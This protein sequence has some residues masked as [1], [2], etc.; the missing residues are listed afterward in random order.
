MAVLRYASGALVWLA[1]LAVLYLA[2]MYN[3]NL[4]HSAA[5]LFSV[6]VALTIFVIAWNTRTILNNNYLLFLG[7]A[8]LFIGVVDV[9]HTLAYKGMGVF[10]GYDANLPTQLWL[11][12]RYL[13]AG[14]L[15]VAPLLLGR[16]LRVRNALA[17]FGAVTGIL[18]LSVF[19]W[20]VFPDAFIEGEGLT[21]FKKL[22]EYVISGAI[23]AGLYLLRRKRDCFEP[24]VLARL[25]LAM[26]ITVASELSFTLYGVDVYGFFNVLGHFLKIAAFYLVYKALVETALNRPYDLLFRELK[27]SEEA[28]RESEERYRTIADSLQEALLVIPAH[29]PGLEFGH[30]YRSA[31]LATRVG[32][33]F[34]D[35][36]EVDSHRVGVLIGD[37]SGKGLKA[38][39]LTS[40][41]KDT[42]RA[43]AYDGASPSETMA[44]AN[45]VLVRSSDPSSFVTAFF[46]ILDRRTGEL[47][48]SSAGHP[49]AVLARR[50][51]T[52][53]FLPTHSPV[54]GAFEN[55]R[56]QESREIL[57]AR[58]V[59]AL[60]TDGVTEA[61]QGPDFY[62]EERLL[63]VL[64]GMNGTPSDR[65]PELIYDDILAHTGG[66]LSDDM[67]VLTLSLAAPP[68]LVPAPA[69]P[70]DREEVPGL[71]DAELAVR[72][73]LG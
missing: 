31:T 38:A 18:L 62:G 22:S 55:M 41:V 9:V 32:G 43:Y 17:G 44:K 7:I 4:F 12:G 61:R 68:G 8:Y 57:G 23:L 50:G 2:R 25:Q 45:D 40:A 27:Q 54:L 73:Q 14:S 51:G 19:V 63:S 48:Y 70:V 26:L 37:V 53:R 35:V 3:Y 6:V 66:N 67:A 5:E 65:V 64:S 58:D 24:S 13:Q 60:Y 36:F 71:V 28:L 16:A 39:T 15:L 46:G 20:P 34:Y 1:I 56:Y 72:S 29:V 49:P 33:D 52:A 47:I 21:T 69:D 30:L 59:L 42:I 11:V 10:V